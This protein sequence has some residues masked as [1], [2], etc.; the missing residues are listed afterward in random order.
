[1]AENNASWKRRLHLGRESLMA[2]ASVYQTMYGQPHPDNPDE[3]S[4]P[5]TFQIVYFIGKFGLSLMS[6][7]YKWVVSKSS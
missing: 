1:M 6:L 5:A 2:A 3:K 4:V 7:I